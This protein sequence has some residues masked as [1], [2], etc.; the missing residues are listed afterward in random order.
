MTRGRVSEKDDPLIDGV[1]E[2]LVLDLREWIAQS[3]RSMKV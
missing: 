1:V 2:A 3:E